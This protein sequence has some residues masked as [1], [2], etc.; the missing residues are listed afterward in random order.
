[1]AGSDARKRFLEMERNSR[2]I[3]IVRRTTVTGDT[4]P[5]L[6]GI[7]PLEQHAEISPGD[8]VSLFLFYNG[9]K[10]SHG[11]LTVWH[12]KARAAIKSPEINRSG[13][14]DEAHGVVVTDETEQ[15]WTIHGEE[16]SG[17][18]AFDLLGFDGILCSG[19][20]FRARS[21]PLAGRHRSPSSNQ[22]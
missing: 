3:E 8:I 13:E 21:H 19:R 11:T 2:V 12:N 18:I 22:F 20:F 4:L 6:Q 15:A 1:M 16:I 9:V 14:W 5:A 10:K 7:I 17:R